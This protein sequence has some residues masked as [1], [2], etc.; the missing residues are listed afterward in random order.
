VSQTRDRAAA[1]DRDPVVT[2]A[3]MIC[4]A[5]VGRAAVTRALERAPALEPAPM[6]DPRAEGIPVPAAP[7]YRPDWSAI[8][9]ILERSRFDGLPADPELRLAAAAVELAL[10]DSALVDDLSRAALVASWEA[11]GMDRLQRGLLRDLLEA[12][13]APRA[14]PEELFDRFYGLHKDAAYSTQSFLHLHLLAR[15]FQVHGRTLFVNNACASGLYALEAAAALLREG[16]ARTAIVV[17]AESPCFPTKRLWF[18]EGGLHSTDGFLRPFDRARTGLILG[19]GSGALVLETRER[20]RERGARVLATYR[21]GHFNQ[22]GWKVAI[23]NFAEPFCEEVIRGAC[24]AA[25]V[26]AESLHGIVA[27]GAGTGLSDAYEAKGITSVLGEWPTRPPVTALKGFFG[28]TL[29]ASALLESA[30]VISCLAEGFLPGAAGFVTP[31]PKLKVQLISKSTPWS[32]G[33]VLKISNGFAG[34]NAGA[35]FEVNP[36]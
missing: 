12:H 3:G 33:C 24:E 1:S 26:S 16:Q 15:A 14:S 32:D 31:D 22:E 13:D 20:A 28:H 8:V 23:P 30:A 9:R 21:G 6:H 36:S 25:E 2:G 19:E 7:L 10:E 34:F 29:G 11:P 5:G 35:I 18:S 4:S 27:H 17:A